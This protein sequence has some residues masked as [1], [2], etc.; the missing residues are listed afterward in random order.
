MKKHTDDLHPII[1]GR[2][3]LIPDYA[4]TIILLLAATFIAAV[5]DHFSRSQSNVSAIYILAVVIVSSITTGY[6]WGILTAACGV[7][8]ANF[9]FT[10][11][12]FALDFTLSGYPLTF[13]MMLLVSLITSTLT[14]RI[15][16]QALFS[17]RRESHTQQLYE[18]TK[19]LLATRGLDNI[20]ELSRNY[21]DALFDCEV[22]FYLDDPYDDK[23][24]YLLPIADAPALSGEDFGAAEIAFSNRIA[25]GAGAGTHSKATH[26]YMPIAT[27]GHSFGVIG[28]SSHD[29]ISLMDEDMTF[30]DMMI[31]Q[32]AMAMERQLLSDD[33]RRI[34]I[35]AE[36]E[37]MRGNLLRAISHDL[38]TPLTGILG[39]S[40]AI[41]E[42][43]GKLSEETHHK[44]V[45]DIREDSQWLIRV[46]ENLLSVTRMRED[47]TN[48]IKTP[49]AVE[50][51][52]GEAIGRVRTRFS[53]RK[54]NVKVPDQLMIVPM[55]GTLIEQVII[56]LI[57]NAVNHSGAS[58]TID[59]IVTQE[60]DFAVFEVADNGEGIPPTMLPNLFTDYANRWST[61]SSDSSRGM[62]IGLSI[63]SS[64][65][66][67][68]KGVIHAEN[69]PE[70]GAR[71]IFKLPLQPETI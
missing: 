63:C 55:D 65:I 21:I 39:A 35:E 69:R 10:Y 48:V 66:K 25:S 37:K 8:G 61:V 49:E 24:G 40:S 50:E 14:A 38:R 17:I 6:I 42:N 33:Q 31:S 27:Q 62:G 22:V 23:E 52:V 13:A 64:I 18:I 59:V 54:I 56:N 46:V 32:I 9:F 44:L 51:I 68:H 67:A 1:K 20:I 2:F 16:E 60:P 12:Y 45:S 3:N 71:F 58:T 34:S 19:K 15:K 36:K 7:V 41:L 53:D 70:G 5:I 47:E 4:K 28:F 30:L 43:G 57:E 29:G 26:F 11:P